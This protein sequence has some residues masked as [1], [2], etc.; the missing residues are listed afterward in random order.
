MFMHDSNQITSGNW[1]TGVQ[2]TPESMGFYSKPSSFNE[3]SAPTPEPTT[4]AITRLLR[5]TVTDDGSISVTDARYVVPEGNSCDCMTYPDEDLAFEE[6]CSRTPAAGVVQFE[7]SDGTCYEMLFDD[8]EMYASCYYD[9]VSLGDSVPCDIDFSSEASSGESDVSTSDSESESDGGAVTDDDS[10]TTTAMEYL[11]PAEGDCNCI[12]ESDD[13]TVVDDTCAD[14]VTWGQIQVAYSDSTCYTLQ[15]DKRDLYASCDYIN[16][17]SGDSQVCSFDL[18]EDT[19]STNETPTTRTPTTTS[20][21][22]PGVIV[23]V[24]PTGKDNQGSASKVADSSAHAS[25]FSAGRL[26]AAI[27]VALLVLN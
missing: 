19:T 1:G 26:L 25:Q 9:G 11:A 3:T 10:A 27:S 16:E 17:R 2:L 4:N 5:Q 6:G 22:S 23:T 14:D 13:Y 21:L 20:P 24:A 15:F 8:T 7:Y 12:A 18:T